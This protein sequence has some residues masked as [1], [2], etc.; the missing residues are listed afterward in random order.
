MRRGFVF[1]NVARRTTVRTYPFVSHAVSLDESV[2][3]WRLD[4]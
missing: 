1:F 4:F 3:S 2:I